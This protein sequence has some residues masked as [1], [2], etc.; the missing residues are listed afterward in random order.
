MCMFLFCLFFYLLFGAVCLE[1]LCFRCD[2]CWVGVS[3]LILVE[4]E[5]FVLFQR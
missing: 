5:I 3:I 2:L 4:N 1:V